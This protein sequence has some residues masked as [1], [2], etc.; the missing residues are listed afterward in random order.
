[1]SSDYRYVVFAPQKQPTV[2]EVD[3]LKAYCLD[4]KLRYAVGVNADDGG[5]AFVFG[6]REFEAAR[7]TNRQFARLL[8]RWA[9][10]GAEVRTQ[11]LF[12]KRPDAL[13]PIPGDL[14]HESV[15]LRTEASLRHKQVA[16]SEAIGEAR[17]RLQRT[18][19]QHAWVQRVAKVVPYA[20]MG[21]AAVLTIVAGSFAYQ[22]LM[23]SPVER[24]QET[25]ERVASDAMGETLSRQSRPDARGPTD[26]ATQ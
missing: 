21:M 8:D 1:M 25:I 7:S 2:R 20:L 18:L 5:L 6:S 13:R 16:A 23:H 9:V 14:L 12:I 17:L 10:R 26:E 19:A 22:R 4:S 24:R 11:L 3:D 15:E